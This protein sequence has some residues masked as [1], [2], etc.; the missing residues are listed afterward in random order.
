M[1]KKA[2]SLLLVMVMSVGMFMSIP[3][4]SASAE[5][6]VIPGLIAW[7]KF[8]ETGGTIAYD[9]SGKGNNAYYRNGAATTEGKIGNAVNMT[10]GSS[11][12]NAPYV[13][14]PQGIMK[15]VEDFTIA[16]WVKVDTNSTW[17]RIFD[18]GSNTTE[19]MFLS[20]YAGNNPRFRYAITVGSNGAEQ[21]T[22][23]NAGLGTGEWK[24]VAV[25]QSGNTVKLYEN[26]VQVAVNNNVTLRP[27]D[28]G[29]TTKNFIGRSQW[30][31]PYLDGLID[32]FR[33][34][35]RALGESEI[36]ALYK[37][38]DY[39]IE[40]I[41]PVDI[42]I[43][44]KDAPKLPGFV[45]V[46]FNDGSTGEVGVVWDPIDPQQYDKE[47]SFTVY[48]TVAG[49]DKKAVANI[50]VLKLKIESIDPVEVFTELYI[51]P[52][53]PEKVKVRYN[54]GTE[55]LVDVVWDVIDYEKLKKVEPFTVEGTVEGTDIK[56]VANVTVFDVFEPYTVEVIPN[57]DS[58]KPGVTFDAKVYVTNKSGNDASVIAIVALYDSYNRMINVSYISKEIALGATERLNAGFKLPSDVTDHRVR[59]LVWDGTTI[60]D[61]KMQPL[62]EVFEIDT[63][64]S[65]IVA[66]IKEVRDSLYI[67]NQ[68]DIRGNITLPTSK[69]GVKIVW[70]AVPEG[71]ITTED[72]PNEGYDPTPAGVVTRGDKDQYVKLKATLYI[73]GY[74]PKFTREFNVRVRAKYEMPPLTGYLYAGFQRI[75]GRE[76]VQKIHFG[77]SDDALWW[78]DLNNAN[79]T[80]ESTMGTKGLRDPYIIRSPEGDKFYLMATDLDARAGNWN[81][82]AT[83]GS[84]S[85]MIWESNDLINWSEQRMVKIAPE[86]AGCTWAPEAIYDEKTGEY[87]V[88]WSAHMLAEGKKSVYI[89]KTR[90]FITFTEPQLFVPAFRA[91]TGVIDTTMIKAGD[92]YYRVSKDEYNNSIFIQTAPQILHTEWSDRVYINGLSGGYEGPGLFKFNG[93]DKWGLMVD[94]YAAGQRRGFIPLYTYDISSLQFQFPAAG[95]YR[96]PSGATHGVIFPITEA[97]KQAL[98]AKWGKS[99]PIDK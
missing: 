47:G 48:G 27:R 58:L 15:D 88:Y 28:L 19:Y 79:P 68:Y 74:K 99:D 71:I 69:D 64:P 51:L 73:P 91:N 9:S 42:V 75:A 32:D 65:N 80:I 7:Y 37:M 57:I 54:N 83:Q 56:A 98:I 67:H 13:E 49:T 76:E 92:T 11:D 25:T 10:G 97:E 41:S 81:E 3:V 96:M 82:Y 78:Y 77:I 14:L 45:T 52:E 63:T 44:E 72:I 6:E 43:F 30:P 34:Y 50:T 36:M 61:S 23:R 4:V 60:D 70:K 22:G 5:D 39:V 18:F 8:D 17:A 12:S 93:E 33:I 89:A 53:L 24:H 85:I 62:S 87:L 16:T 31:D 1:S 20:P 86:G 2:I 84:D 66:K 94:E 59:V 46:K 40:E 21:I 26:G 38:E 55:S 29:E 95:T 90:D 35:N